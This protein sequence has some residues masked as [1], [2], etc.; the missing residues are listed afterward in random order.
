MMKPLLAIAFVAVS[1]SPRPA[2]A[3]QKF[4]HVD[5]RRALEESNE[6]KKAAAQ[7][8]AEFDKK[9]KELEQ[10]QDELRKVKADI[11]RQAATL[12]ADALVAKQKEL[13][14]RAVQLQESYVR[15]QREAQEKQASNTQRITR[16]LSAIVAQ[17]A[18]AQGLTY[19][20]DSSV[21]LVFA[22]PSLDL[23]SELIRK[24]DST[25]ATK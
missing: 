21:G 14:Q 12:K 8:K 19:V 5:L 4:A 1:I 10:R 7:L 16:Q 20:L 13:E 11:D 15:L 9:Q 25:P 6:G 24:Y 17:I 2:A 18:Q 22:P 3:E 23:T